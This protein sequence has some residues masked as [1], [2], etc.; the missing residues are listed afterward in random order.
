MPCTAF[1]CHVKICSLFKRFLQLISEGE[2]SGRL[3]ESFERISKILV[4]ELS[5]ESK[6]KMRSV[7]LY[8]F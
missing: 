8:F 7:I 2:A 6:L 1:F 5:L 4:K 3:V